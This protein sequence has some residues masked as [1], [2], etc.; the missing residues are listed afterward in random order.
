MKHLLLGGLLAA[1]LLA[2]PSAR[3]G[4][5]PAAPAGH[6]TLDKHHASLVFRLSHLGFSHYTAQF[7]R[8]DAK[9]DIDP[10]KP[11]A[12]RVEAVIDPTSLELPTPPEGF[13]DALLGPDW[14]DVKKYPSIVFRSTKVTPTGKHKARI[15][16]DLTLH[17]VTKPVTL[18]A[19]FNGGYPGFEMDPNARIGFSAKGHFRR[20]DF[21]IKYGIPAPG[22]NMGVGDE[23]DLAIETEFSGPAWKAPK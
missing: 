10:A 18:E 14:L 7:T 9:L 15:T 5:A 12:A 20:S 2:A 3:A 8:F 17:G 21:G 1:L 6:Y 11:S 16:G 19:T 22:S 23:I 4:T 13:K